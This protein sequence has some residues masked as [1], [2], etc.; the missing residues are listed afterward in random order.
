MKT[1]V[2]SDLHIGSKGCQTEAILKL[3]EKKYDR[4]ILVGDIVDGWLFKKYKKFTY[5]HTK[6]I[7]RLLKLSKDAEIIWIAG[8]HDEFLRKYLG[9][10]IGN[11]QIVDEWVENGV[12]F[13]H[14]DRYDGVVKLR[15]LGVLGSIGYDLAIVLDRLLKRTGYN[16][17]LSKY[18]KNNVKAAI[19]FVV[20]FENEMIRQA[21][22]R[23]CDVVVCGHIHNPEDKR[24]DGVRYLNTGDWVENC[25]YIEYEYHYKHFKLWKNL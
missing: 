10:E 11:I 8:N 12:W 7:R 2:I 15:W 6:V 21:K 9:T 23:N 18:L 20:D 17:S 16:F 1:L 24:I 25:S 13:C 5:E 22:K 19:S 14:G 3:L 4:Y